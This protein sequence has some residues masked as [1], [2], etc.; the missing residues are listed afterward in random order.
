MN[1]RYRVELTESE[2]GELEGLLRG[3]KHP[4]RKLKRAQVL[5]AADTGTGDGQ[6]ARTVAVS[7]STVYRTRQGFVEGNLPWALSERPRAG[8]AR[9]LTD[10]E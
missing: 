8:A 5:L 4:V 2:R 1:P 3:G 6:I 9:K 10:K 7:L